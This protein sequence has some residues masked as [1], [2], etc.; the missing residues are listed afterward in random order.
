MASFKKID[1]TFIG[2]R[3][4]K[5]FNWKDKGGFRLRPTCKCILTLRK[6][7]KNKNKKY[8]SVNQFSSDIFV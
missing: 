4:P 8:K 2:D 7:I 5:K 3:S 6:I 1:A